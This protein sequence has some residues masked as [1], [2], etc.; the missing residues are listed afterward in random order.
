MST[1]TTSTTPDDAEEFPSDFLDIDD[2]TTDQ[3]ARVLARASDLKAGKD[4]TQ[5]GIPDEEAVVQRYCRQTGRESIP[6]WPFYT[7]FALFRLAAILQGVYKRGLDG[8]ASSSNAL[9]M[10]KGARVLAEAG[11]KEAE[12]LESSK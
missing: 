4:L 5:L 7:A 12:K 6:H 8:N 3:L 11:W 1:H 9:E 2:L 10:G